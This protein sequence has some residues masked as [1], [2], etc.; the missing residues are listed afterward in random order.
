MTSTTRTREE[1]R[2]SE[3]GFSLIE[4]LLGLSL[5]LCL[6]LA[7]APVWSSAQS[8]GVR[9]SDAAIGVL[10]GRVV[11]GRIEKDLRLAT[12]QHCP[13]AVAGAILDAQPAQVVFLT[14]DSKGQP[15][16]IVEWEIAGSALMRRKGT[17]PGT[18]P[19]T[20][21]HSLYTD[22]KTM[23]D[24][25]RPGGQF[26]YYVGGVAVTAPVPVADL[27]LV[28]KVDLKLT[29]VPPWDVHGLEMELVVSAPVGR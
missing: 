8:R 27:P 12:A 14:S 3:P 9:D 26:T 7:L 11:A 19:V 23:L 5:T 24:G 25:L 20:F 16:T 18:K 15:P 17:C 29:H 13:F 28:D 10:E 6:A 1:C 22:H 2:R 21:P 4:L